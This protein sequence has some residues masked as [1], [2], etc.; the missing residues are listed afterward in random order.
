MLRRNSG[1]LLN[2]GIINTSLLEQIRL[3]LWLYHCKYIFFFF[4]KYIWWYLLHICLCNWILKLI[5]VYF[6]HF[7]QVNKRYLLLY[8]NFGSAHMSIIHTN[9]KSM[10]DQMIIIITSVWSQSETGSSDFTESWHL[11]SSFTWSY[12]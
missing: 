1:V 6:P 3:L 7:S 10:I 9:W 4:Q 2:N 11:N 12:K 8:I 5:F